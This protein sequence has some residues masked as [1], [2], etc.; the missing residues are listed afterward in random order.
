MDTYKRAPES[1]EEET[2]ETDAAAAKKSNESYAESKEEEPGA[3][4]GKN[5]RR[6]PYLLTMYWTRKTKTKGPHRRSRRL[7]LLKRSRI[8][9]QI[10]RRLQV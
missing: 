6:D 10:R 5:R 1:Q 4:G 3:A 9:T 8:R 2:E 7:L